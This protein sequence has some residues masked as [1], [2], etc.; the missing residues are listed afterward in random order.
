MPKK[1]PAAQ[2]CSPAP[3]KNKFAG[4][5]TPLTLDVERTIQFDE[6]SAL[7]HETI[8]PWPS[9]LGVDQFYILR[10][11][12]EGACDHCKTFKFRTPKPLIGAVRHLRTK[13]GCHDFRSA[14]HH[15]AVQTIGRRVL[16]CDPEKAETH[17]Q[18]VAAG[19]S[20][21][22]YH[23]EMS[24]LQVGS[25]AGTTISI[26]A[27][28][29]TSASA[30]QGMTNHENNDDTP[31]L[32]P[33]GAEEVDESL[34]SRR[35]IPSAEE[36]DPMPAFMLRPGRPIDPTGSQTIPWLDNTIVRNGS[37]TSPNPWEL[38]DF[39]EEDAFETE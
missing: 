17:N 6:V 39:I 19:V 5:G 22:A 38:S 2:A 10:C 29:G 23:S 37:E 24:S 8:F 30:N 27:G 31:V 32:Q 25:E 34:G 18:R 4:K 3:K 14:D 36:S 12:M 21:A 16:G 11:D 20:T 28:Q 26:C 13:C 35:G 7:A 1:R 15:F 9:S 33:R